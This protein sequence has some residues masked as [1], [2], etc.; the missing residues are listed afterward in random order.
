MPSLAVSG[1]SLH[2][3]Q[4]FAGTTHDE[5]VNNPESSACSQVAA[6]WV[7]FLFR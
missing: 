3:L 1:A 5:W 4:T 7:V 2:R 6:V